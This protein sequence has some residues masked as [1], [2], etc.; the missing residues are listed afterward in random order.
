MKFST[1]SACLIGKL[2]AQLDAYYGIGILELETP[3]YSDYKGFT[4]DLR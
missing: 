1:V 2:K 3:Y 4:G